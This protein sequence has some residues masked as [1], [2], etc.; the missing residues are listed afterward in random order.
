MG[1]FVVRISHVIIQGQLSNPDEYSITSGNKWLDKFEN[2]CVVH[3]DLK[4][5]RPSFVV[6]WKN[7]RIGRW[8][9][10]F[11]MSSGWTLKNVTL[12]Y[13]DKKGHTILQ[14]QPEEFRFHYNISRNGV[15]K[16]WKV[17]KK[18]FTSVLRWALGNL[19]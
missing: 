8:D 14:V 12:T 3:T 10:D 16:N 13:I 11:E 9:H 2:L 15:I 5:S 6:D 18:D 7:G 17:R 19:V 1:V 4:Q